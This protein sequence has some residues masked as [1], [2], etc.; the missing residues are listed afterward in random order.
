MK[1]VNAYRSSGDAVSALNANSKNMKTINGNHSIF[2]TVAKSFVNP[3][4]AILDVL[5]SHDADNI[6]NQKI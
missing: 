1:S 2:E 3:L 4:G 6:E 5:A